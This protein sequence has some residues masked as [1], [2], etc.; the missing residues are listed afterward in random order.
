MK[1]IVNTK[2]QKK[3]TNI[4]YENISNINNEYTVLI[5]KRDEKLIKEKPELYDLTNTYVENQFE[6]CEVIEKNLEEAL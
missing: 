4:Y 5:K 6:K 2:V 3:E 1:Y